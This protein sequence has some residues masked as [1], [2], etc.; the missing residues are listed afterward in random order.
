MTTNVT[1]IDA[2]TFGV[3]HTEGF[4]SGINGTVSVTVAAASLYVLVLVQTW[5]KVTWTTQLAIN[6]P[7]THSFTVSGAFAIRAVIDGVNQQTPDSVPVPVSATAQ[8]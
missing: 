7:G 6:A 3:S 8:F 2:A 5:D 1:L 4:D